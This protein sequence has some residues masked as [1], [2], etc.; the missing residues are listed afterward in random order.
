MA[1]IEKRNKSYR[2]KVSCGYDTNGK[3]VTQSMTWK[4]D[5]GMTERQIEKELN[6]QVVLFEE[7]CLKGNIVTTVKFEDF[8][9]Q[10]F[11]E[12]ADRCLKAQT[13]R[14]Y[15]YLEPR[16]YK[17][18]G[19]LRLDKITPRHIQKF[20]NEL[21]EEKRNDALGEKGRKLSP[22][23]VKLHLSLVSTIYDYAI[24]MQM[25]QSN[26][27]KNVQLPSPEKK[28]R[29]I[30]TLEEAQH[31]LELF[32]QEEENNFKY[33]VFFMIAL[34]TGFRRGELLGLEWKDI[35]WDS[36]II[37]ISRT[38]AWTKEKG[39][40]TDTP[41]TEASMRS[42]QIP[43]ELAEIIKKYK[44]WQ[45]DYKASIGDQWIENDRLFT[46]WNGKPMNATAPYNFLQAFC[47]RH[48]LRFCSIH[49][50]RHLNAA[51][52]ITNG[53]DLKTVQTCLGHSEASTTMSVYLHTFQEA[54]AKAMGAVAE[55]ISF[56]PAERKN[57]A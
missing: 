14:G 17:A 29:D 56:K 21:S 32:E 12:Y 11:E 50:F 48:D 38:S 35:N 20:I 45:E 36:N 57:P 26:P 9:R 3:Q 24:K 37:T 5:E 55:A 47:K 52:L 31:I 54:Q 23:T 13:V 44:A 43:N 15:H 1:Q 19:H 25:V 27:C 18:I 6:R 40:Y 2:I 4:P 7:A 46:Q 22:K 30:Y 34:Y 33:V 8:A 39:T 16:I 42:L 49:S 51:L 28:E 10:W 41:K 53:V